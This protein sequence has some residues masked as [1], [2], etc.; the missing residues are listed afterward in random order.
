MNVKWG[1][2]S[3][4]RR[5]DWWL[6]G[7]SLNQ[8]WVPVKGDFGIIIPSTKELPRYA[9]QLLF[10]LELKLLFI[11]FLHDHPPSTQPK[12][13]KVKRVS[14]QWGTAPNFSPSGFMGSDQW[15][16]DHGLQLGNGHQPASWPDLN[17]LCSIC[18]S[19]SII[20]AV[21]HLS[22]QHIPLSLAFFF[23]LI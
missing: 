1:G 8:K 12:Q 16:S 18:F 23:I 3:G 6:V 21:W 7:L 14:F 11:N 9:C 2:N 5:S 15:A 19:I 20:V 10:I 4:K 13:E 22:W 17:Y